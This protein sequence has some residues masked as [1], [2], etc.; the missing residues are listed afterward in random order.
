MKILYLFFLILFLGSCKTSTPDLSTTVSL[1]YEMKTPKELSKD[2]PILI[3]LHGYGSNKKDLFGFANKL[4]ENLVVACPQA[5][6]TL[7]NNRYA[8]YN[9]NLNASKNRYQYEDVQLAKKEIVKFIQEIKKKYGLS[10]SKV[11][12]GG[13]S[14]GAIMSL[15]LGLSEP[16]LIDG[17]IA[18]SG[19]LYPEVRKAIKHNPN[20]SDLKIFMSHGKQDNVLSFEKA[21]EGYHYLNNH[22]IKV[23]Q[24][25]YDS[26][27]QITSENFRDLRS[28]LDKQL[29][30]D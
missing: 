11:F 9:L 4:N 18:L 14:Q 30:K 25:W 12:V 15:Y 2:S 3:L 13:F 28:W 22:G 21:E 8:W 10:K 16:E 27:H 23:D 7:Q 17:V 6:I 24:F 5:P 26:K 29:E 19:H 20:L 1:A